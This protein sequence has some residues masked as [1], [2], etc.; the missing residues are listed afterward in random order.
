MVETALL[1]NEMPN[2]PR[3]ISDDPRVR[4]VV[5]ILHDTYQRQGGR[6]AREQVERQADKRGLDPEQL[7]LVL[8]ALCAAG[9]QIEQPRPVGF[10]PKGGPQQPRNTAGAKRAVSVDFDLLGAFFN[11]IGRYPL[12]TADDEVTLA[13]RIHL[14]REAAQRLAAGE[15]D[16]HLRAVV[17]R[18]RSAFE[19]MV[20]SNLRLVVSIARRYQTS[21]SGLDF[22]DLVQEGTFGLMRAVEKFDH[23]KGFK[24]S[25]YATW[26]IRQAITR[27]IA[28]RG[29]LIRIP[30]HALEF[31]RKL[32]AVRTRLQGSS[33]SEPTAREIAEE[34]RVEPEQ[35]QFYLD[36]GTTLAPVSL[37]EPI[38][39]VDEEGGE[40]LEFLDIPY[41][42]DPEEVAEALEIGRLLRDGVDHLP[43]SEREVLTRRYGLDDDRPKTLEEVGQVFGVTRERIRQIEAKALQHIRRSSSK[44][45]REYVDDPT[46]RLTPK[47]VSS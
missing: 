25:T 33:G 13:R 34:L 4:R 20:Q 42:D 40:L 47:G 26:W 38:S 6:L 36:L 30:V 12:L 2:E 22:L 11:D 15:D 44:D 7:G 3:M 17:R 16:P 31:L 14:G 10:A 19:T 32:A 43:A 39:S 5:G 23:T 28:D 1:K 24:F 29:R 9:V 37:D 41:F 21:T 46:H 27:G 45:L 35:V 8:E 18:G